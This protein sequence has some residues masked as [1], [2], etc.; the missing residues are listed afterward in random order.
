MELT[1]WN[2]ARFLVIHVAGDIVHQLLQSLGFGCGTTAKRHMTYLHIKKKCIIGI[3][4]PLGSS[5]ESPGP[6][7]GCGVYI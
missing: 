5:S 6:P 4:L 1:T 2:F 3:H 7:F